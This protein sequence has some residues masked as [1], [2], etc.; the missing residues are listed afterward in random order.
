MRR[1]MR[2]QYRTDTLRIH[3][4]DN[5]ALG[6]QYMFAQLIARVWYP[7]SHPLSNRRPWPSL[8]V[9]TLHR[10]PP[11]LSTRTA[12]IPPP[13][14]RHI[15]ILSKDGQIF[16]ASLTINGYPAGATV[17]IASVKCGK[18]SDCQ[19]EMAPLPPQ[20]PAAIPRMAAMPAHVPA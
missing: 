12:S 7:T 18:A 2:G 6:P 13:P 17:R 10:A 4:Q 3:M 19:R 16:S 11:L 14:A 20:M 15:N 8:S 5:T 1:Q 9:H